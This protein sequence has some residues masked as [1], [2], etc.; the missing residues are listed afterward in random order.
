MHAGYGTIFQSFDFHFLIAAAT[1]AVAPSATN[2][3]LRIHRAFPDLP[4]SDTFHHSRS[5]SRDEPACI[6]NGWKS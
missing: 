6:G 2:R 3:E 1:E 5:S 4:L